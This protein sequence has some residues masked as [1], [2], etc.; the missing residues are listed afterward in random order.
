MFFIFSRRKSCF[1]LDFKHWPC[2]EFCIHSF[3][4]SFVFWIVCADVSEHLSVPSSCFLLD[5]KHWP[6]SEFCILY[7][8][9]SSVYW[10]VCADVSEHLSVPS[11]CVVLG[12]RII[13]TRLLGYLYILMFISFIDL[14]YSGTKLFDLKM[15]YY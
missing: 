6:F 5:F 13:G 11:S 3:G 9:S 14:L 4:S 1:L 2:S 12:G 7:F 8:G 10:I 15:S